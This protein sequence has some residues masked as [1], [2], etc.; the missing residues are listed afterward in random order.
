MSCLQLFSS[1]HWNHFVSYK[2]SN[3]DSSV[4]FQSSILGYLSSGSGRC[5]VGC[6]FLILDSVILTCWNFVRSLCRRPMVKACSLYKVRNLHG[7]MLYWLVIDRIVCLLNRSFLFVVLP[8]YLCQWSCYFAL[9]FGTFR[10]G[11]GL[12][13]FFEDWPLDLFCTGVMQTGHFRDRFFGLLVF[14]T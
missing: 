11:S 9:I 13:Q 7:F 12:F 8:I 6:C 14:D 3:W 2:L 4:I 5:G 1:S 10:A